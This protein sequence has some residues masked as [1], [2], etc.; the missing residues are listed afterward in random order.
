M[1]SDD[2]SDSDAACSTDRDDSFGG[3][4]DT[5]TTTYDDDNDDDEDDSNGI[6]AG[7]EAGASGDT[8]KASTSSSL[9]EGTGGLSQRHLANTSPMRAAQGTATPPGLTLRNRTAKP[10][11]AAMAT[12]TVAAARRAGTAPTW[13]VLVEKCYVM[14][15]CHR[16][17]PLMFKVRVVRLR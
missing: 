6:G 2:E 13:S 15:S 7:T 8:D 17:H 12:E 11:A 9:F 14:I 10:R 4:V 3:D 16:N 1:F 5:I